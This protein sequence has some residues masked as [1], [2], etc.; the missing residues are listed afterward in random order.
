MQAHST[1]ARIKTAPKIVAREIVFV[2]RWKICIDVQCGGPHYGPGSCSVAWFTS[3]HR[4]VIFNMKT[5]DYS[6][7]GGRSCTLEEECPLIF[8]ENVTGNIINFVNCPEM[9]LQRKFMTSSL[10]SVISSIA[11]RRP[12]RP[13]PDSFTPP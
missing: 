5:C 8:F 6:R 7:P 12:S 4:A 3:S 9:K 10:G 2:L 13:K 11:Y 1:A